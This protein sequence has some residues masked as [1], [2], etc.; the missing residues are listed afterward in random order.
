LSEVS[1]RPAHPPRRLFHDRSGPLDRI[2]SVAE[3]LAIQ[4]NRV[5]PCAYGDCG[6]RA[7]ELVDLR[8]QGG[9]EVERIRCLACARDFIRVWLPGEEQSGG[10]ACA[11]AS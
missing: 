2:F 11:D 5:Q 10:A 3:T 7:C 6:A 4:R 9:R 1:S 8:N